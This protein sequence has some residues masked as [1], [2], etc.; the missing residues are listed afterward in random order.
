MA[1]V[2]VWDM[3]TVPD[4]GGFAA[5]NALD[6]KSD[7][8]IRAAIGDKLPSVI[9]RELDQQSAQQPLDSTMTQTAPI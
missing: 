3:E 9:D 5:A 4:L 1:H 6:G 2:L 8:E 7:D